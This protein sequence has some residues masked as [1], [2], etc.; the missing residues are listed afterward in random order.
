MAD[1]WKPY[2]DNL[3]GSKAAT[4]AAIIGILAEENQKGAVW[5]Q[6][7]DLGVPT[8]DDPDVLAIIDILQ[9][10]NYEQARGQLQSNGFRFKGTKYIMTRFEGGHHLYGSKSGEGCIIVKS[11]RTI[12]LAICDSSIDQK[13]CAA[14]VEGLA[15]YL[16]KMN[17]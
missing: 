1:P 15:D 14:A 8:R 4:K 2:I 10:P 7:A 16:R 17:Y 6:S 3:V 12:I 5:T 11:A 13:Q 9:N